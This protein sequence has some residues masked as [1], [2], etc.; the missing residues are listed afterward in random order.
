MKDYIKLG[1]ILFIIAAVASGILAFVNNVTSPIISENQ[2]LNEQ[3]ARNEV[4]PD[5]VKFEE[6]DSEIVYYIGFDKEDNVVGYTF[7]AEGSGYSGV[8]HTM[9]GVD[10]E[11]KINRIKVILQSETPGLGA[12][13]E[14][15]EFTDQFNGRIKDE[16][17]VDK[18]GGEIVSI[19]GATI[20]SRAITES[21]SSMMKVV[22]LDLETSHNDTFVENEEVK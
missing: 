15:P 22:A 1:G 2:L 12:N 10:T 19:T 21:L 5:A 14:N 17:A 7:V 9:V 8:L 16:L 18:D 20:T 3:S 6:V 13:S 11:F 4:L